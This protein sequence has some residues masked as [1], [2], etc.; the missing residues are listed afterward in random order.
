M[1]KLVVLY[2]HP[3][4]PAA[5]EE[6]YVSRHF[7]LADKMPYVRRAEMAKALPG[8]DGSPPPFYRVAE[9]YYDSLEDLQASNE[10]PEGEAT[11][12]DLESFATGGVTVFAAEVLDRQEA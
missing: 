4:D 3:D 2:G 11:R 5:F 6:Y 1:I 8:P 9:V 12:A 10:S 7:P